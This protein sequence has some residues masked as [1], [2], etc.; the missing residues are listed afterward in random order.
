MA[1]PQR[2]D[3]G[4][5]QRTNGNGGGQGADLAVF[6]MK[7]LG[8]QIKVALPKHLDPDRM[9]RVALT[10]LRTVPKLAQCD[11]YSFA[12]CILQAAQLGLEVC[13]PLG[14]A[15]LIPRKNQCTLLIGYRGMLDLA[16]RSGQVSSLYA[17]TVHEGDAFSYRLGLDPTL[18]HV[19]NVDVE[20]NEK[21]MTFVYAVAKLR[22]GE[23]DRQFVVLSKRQVNE[24]K[25]RGAG[26][27]AWSTDYLA[28]A[29]K[30]AVRALFTWLP[31]SPEMAI[32]AAIDEEP[33]ITKALDANVA[34]ALDA[35][36]LP[37]PAEVDD[38]GVIEHATAADYIAKIESADALYAAI[39]AD[40]N[41]AWIR[42]NP[43]EAR[44]VLKAAIERTGADANRVEE[45]LAD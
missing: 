24:R 9:A 30:T 27:N 37:P 13:T 20:Q 1:G 34:E 26:G 21:T 15:Y 5:I 16:R 14:H 38:D 32:A 6:L 12:A 18:D 40:E 39:S 28:M 41:R 7:E 45:L 43:D 19:P 11:R 36:K 42:D 29:K 44:E 35:M 10:A 2:N 17:H 3:R 23:H 25:A 8:P 4:Q 22:T 33:R 31:S